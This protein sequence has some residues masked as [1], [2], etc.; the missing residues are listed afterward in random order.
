MSYNQTDSDVWREE[1]AEA[2]MTGLHF[3]S[4][5]EYDA[6]ISGVTLEGLLVYDAMKVVEIAQKLLK[7]TTEEAHEYAEFEIF[8]SFFANSPMYFWPVEKHEALE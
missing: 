6:A 4:E 5:H 1:L 2:H 8:G 3:L 7:C